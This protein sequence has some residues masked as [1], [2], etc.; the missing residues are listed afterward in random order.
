MRI[1]KK[2]AGARGNL[3]FLIKIAVLFPKLLANGFLED[4]GLNF[5]VMPRYDLDLE[6]LFIANKRRFK[7]ETTITIG[8]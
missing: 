6:R 4:K 3:S 8:L 5:I 7:L 2:V 1:I